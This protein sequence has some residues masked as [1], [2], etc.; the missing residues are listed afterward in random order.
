MAAM[1]AYGFF[2]DIIR[3]SD[4]WRCLGPLRYDVSGICQFF[5]NKSYHTQIAMKL[6]PKTLVMTG[7]QEKHDEDISCTRGLRKMLN[8][9]P[10]EKK[11]TDE[12]DSKSKHKK[13]QSSIKRKFCQRHCETCADLSQSLDD[14]S[15]VTTLDVR[16][17]NY[18]AINC[19]NMPG[20]CGKSKFGMSPYVH[21]GETELHI[22]LLIL[23]KHDFLR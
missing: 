6:A 8:I 4:K 9:C 5:R 22:F 18:T 20:R 3:Q 1:L 16:Q 15:C 12:N 14:E 10:M 23:F 7:E 17:G 13:T 21:L 19:L 11:K 2:G